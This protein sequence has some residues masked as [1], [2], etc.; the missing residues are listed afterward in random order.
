[1]MKCLKYKDF[2]KFYDSYMEDLK[3]KKARELPPYILQR[4]S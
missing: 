2:M 3:N 1:M 4:V